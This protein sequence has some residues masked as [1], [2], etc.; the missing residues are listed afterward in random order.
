MQI[1]AKGN[2]RAIARGSRHA[3][4][5]TK[6]G[7][8]LEESTEF[9]VR[10]FSTHRGCKHGSRPSTFN[11]TINR[12]AFAQNFQFSHDCWSLL[13]FSKII[14]VT[15]SAEMHR[16]A[17]RKTKAKR[18]D[19]RTD[20]FRS[21][22]YINIDDPLLLRGEQKFDRN[23][24]RSRCTWLAPLINI[25]TGRLVSAAHHLVNSAHLRV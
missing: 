21:M 10:P 2:W 6:R 16:V 8:A 7:R 5:I 11:F 24:G 20:S 25:E 13:N 1:Y 23:R 4:W 18:I 15:S 17:S 3:R 22:S 9:I 14:D 12:V 19:E